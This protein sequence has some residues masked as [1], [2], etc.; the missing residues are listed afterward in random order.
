M[1]NLRYGF[2][3]KYLALETES[4]KEEFRKRHP[5]VDEVIKIVEE[6]DTKTLPPYLRNAIKIS[7]WANYNA[8]SPSAA[9]EDIEE[10]KLG[11]DL[12]SIRQNLIKP[13]MSKETEEERKSF[14]SAHPETDEVLDIISNLDLEHGTKKNKELALLIKQD[15]IVR[16]TLREAKKLEHEYRLELDR[17]KRNLEL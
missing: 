14:R 5:Y 3:N 1:A 13:Y 9:S 7:K 10:R 2:I 6:I 17:K 15:L 4:E 11:K 16:S 8:K 12:S